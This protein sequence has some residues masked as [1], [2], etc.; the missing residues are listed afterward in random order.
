MNKSVLLLFLPLLCACSHP[1][2]RVNTYSAHDP[3]DAPLKSHISVVVH[4]GANALAPENTMPSADSAL[5]H[6][7]EWIEVDVRTTVDGA[8]YN[9]HD[10]ELER[11]TTGTGRI[12]ERTA[13]YIET[14]DA[15]SWFGEQYR[16]LKV[17]TMRAMLDTLSTRTLSDGQGRAK[18]FFDVKPGTPVPAIVELVRETGFADLSFFWFARE[19]MLR[20]FLSLAHEMQVKVN[21]N[22]TVRLQYWIDLVREYQRPA[23]DIVEV[24]A[25][26]V[27]PAFTA[28]CRRHQIRIMVGAQGE[29][30]DDYQ[31]AIETGAD[32]INLDKP[33]LFEQL[34]RS[35]P[36]VMF[37]CPGGKSTEQLCTAPLQHLIDS[38]S[39]VGGGT[40]RL[41][42]GTYLS[43]ML[44]LRSH[45]ELYLDE[46]ATLLGSTNPY[47][48]DQPKG[49]GVRGDEDVHVGLIVADSA[50]DIAVRGRGVI[51]GQGLDLALAIDSLHHIG[52]RIDPNYNVRRMRPSTRPKL[53]FLDHTNGIRI[54]GVTLRNSAGWGLSCD[55]SQNI[56]IR[57]VTVYN[58]A[59]WNNDGIDLNDCRHAEIAHCEINSADDGICLKSDE[60][61]RGCEDIYIHDCRIASSASA[62]KFGTASWGGFR[63]VRVHDIEVYDTFRSAIALETVDGGLMED[64]EVDGIEARNTGNPLFVCLGARHSEARHSEARRI[65]IRNVKAEVPFGRPDEAYDLRGPEVNYF[66]NPW[67]SSIAGLPGHPIQEVTLE[68]IDL[69]YPGRAS[70]AMAYIGLYRLDAVN[71]AATA[72]PEFSMYGE[73]PSWALYARHIQGLTLRNIR[74][75]LRD[76]DFRPAFIFDD[77]QELTLDGITLPEGM[78]EETQIVRF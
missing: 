37:S 18:V 73:L 47:D 30:L 31:K 58:R 7:A 22:D 1:S 51:D 61:A 43:G 76:S 39:A 52:E 13:E 17:P 70:K 54:E 55:R 19:E 59:Y 26:Q 63:R 29:S 28:F 35:S 5:A 25:D 8:M 49:I 46:G 27:T 9:L 53:F 42:P 68:N 65:T 34:Q 16:G 36:V 50:V 67:P 32:L 2:A 44:R 60:L 33:E 75:S 72:Y 21:A 66:H 48:Y 24:H 41:L 78:S 77:V 6:G 64:I 38:L 15:G 69:T 74:V 11:T 40:L 3:L 56:L 57:D 45:V 10:D 23:P 12:S 71:E 62:V 20:E 14:L 4:R